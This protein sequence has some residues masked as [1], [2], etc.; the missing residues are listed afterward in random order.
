MRFLVIL[1]YVACAMAG[2][3]ALAC[4]AG[5]CIAPLVMP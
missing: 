1:T 5:A 2:C 3:I 4:A